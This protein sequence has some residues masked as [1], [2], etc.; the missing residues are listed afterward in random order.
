[1]ILSG[2]LTLTVGLLPVWT[3]IVPCAQRRPVDRP[4]VE[5]MAFGSFLCGSAA[6]IAWG[7]AARGTEFAFASRYNTPTLLLW[8][9][10]LAGVARYARVSAISP[11]VSS[12]VVICIMLLSLAIGGISTTR[13]TDA[14]NIEYYSTRIQQAAYFIASGVPSDDQLGSIFPVP[15]AIR[16]PIRFLQE[17][18]LSLFSERLGLQ[19]PADLA[20]SAAS[21]HSQD[22]QM[23]WVDSVD[24]LGDYGWRIVG[25]A[26]H[27]ITGSAPTLVLAFDGQGRLRGFT[28][29]LMHRPDVISAIHAPESFRGFSAPISPAPLSNTAQPEADVVWLMAVFRDGQRCRMGGD[30]RLPGIA[31]P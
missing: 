12:G 27:P 6:A 29:P 17:H 14:V 11:R 22:C 2:A 13:S 9:V 24:R 1:V 25:W 21:S 5:L 31:S 18:R 30:R 20:I 28:K 3:V 16:V 26:A 8:M 4:L 10:A 23:S 7:R 19:L 15:S